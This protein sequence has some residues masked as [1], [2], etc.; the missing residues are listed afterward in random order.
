M[1]SNKLKLKLLCSS[2][3]STFYG[4]HSVLRQYQLAT[5][6]FNTAGQHDSSTQNC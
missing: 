1:E 2:L 5:R 6:H 4:Y 3:L